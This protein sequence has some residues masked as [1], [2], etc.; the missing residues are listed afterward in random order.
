MKSPTNV[1]EMEMRLIL[2]DT[3]EWIY[4]AL[5]GICGQWK[6]G[7]QNWRHARKGS[8]SSDE[9]SPCGFELYSRKQ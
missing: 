8:L 1:I 7:Q 2:R 5:D 9:D 4:T 6:H 3:F